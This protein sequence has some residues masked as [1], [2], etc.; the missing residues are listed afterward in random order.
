[1]QIEASN[2][3]TVQKPAAWRSKLLTPLNFERLIVWGGALVLWEWWG[4][5]QSP[6]LF[7]YPTAILAAE[8]E[9]FSKGQLLGEIGE[10]LEALIIAFAFAAAIAVVL[11]LLAGRFNYL[12]RLLHPLMTAFYTTPRLALVPLIIVWIGIGFEAKVTIIWLSCFFPIYFNVLPGMTSLSRTYIDVAHAYGANEWETL[13]EVILPAILPFIATGL[14]L[15][16]AMALVGMI[17]AEFFVG[18]TGLGGVILFHAD[19]KQIAEVFAAVLV[20]LCMGLALMSAAY[21][22]ERR[23]SHWRQTERAFR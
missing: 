10:S 6:F 23:V 16:L 3:Q 2:N 15:G 1:M 19:R 12:R 7:T 20:V 8:Y 9:L 5:K 18:L 4:S 22:F 13:R 17:T 11:G 14:R 21:A